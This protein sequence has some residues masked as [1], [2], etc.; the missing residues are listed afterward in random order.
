MDAEA[1]PRRSRCVGRTDADLV[2][3]SDEYLGWT[4]DTPTSRAHRGFGLPVTAADVGGLLA[5]EPACG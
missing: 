2:S 1:L 4:G 3:R 5:P